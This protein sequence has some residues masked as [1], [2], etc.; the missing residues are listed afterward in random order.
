MYL[1][2]T[3]WNKSVAVYRRRLVKLVCE[4]YNKLHAD[5]PEKERREALKAL[6]LEYGFSLPDPTSLKAADDDE[7][8]VDI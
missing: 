2:V 1:R 3:E 7:R 6:L 8:A 4:K 5:V